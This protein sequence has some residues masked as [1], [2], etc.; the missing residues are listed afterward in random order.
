MNHT[1]VQK[2]YWN[3]L[4]SQVP[5]SIACT[6]AVTAE[7]LPMDGAAFRAVAQYLGRKFLANKAGGSILEIGCGNGLVLSELQKL[8]APSAFSLSGADVSPE[9]IART[10]IPSATLY[11]CDAKNIP[12]ASS[13]FDLIYLHSVVQYFDNDVYMREVVAEYMRL[14][15]PGGDLCFLDVPLTWY[16]PY[17]IGT[18]RG[19]RHFLRTNLPALQ[20][21]YRKLRGKSTVTPTSTQVVRTNVNGVELELPIFNG[22]W[23]DPDSFYGYPFTS[24]S[25]EM[26]P[27]PE[28]PL[29]YRKF[30]FNV[31][32]KNLAA[33]DG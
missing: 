33:V 29:T 3:S 8:L 1:E 15:K 20:A 4:A 28:K 14:L 2:K 6:H 30:R 13:Q 7:N 17:M 19:I 11:C 26:Q 12:V 24:I 16:K 25:I 21:L 22:Y 18:P 32:M 5:D 9:M 10:I 23:A 31:L 27:Y